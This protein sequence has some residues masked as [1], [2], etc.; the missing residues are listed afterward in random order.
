MAVVARGEKLIAAWSD[1]SGLHARLLT[2][3]G[4]VVGAAFRLGERCNGGLAMAENGQSGRLACMRVGSDSHGIE[5]IDILYDGS[6]RSVARIPTNNREGRGV[7]LAIHGSETHVVWSE[8]PRAHEQVWRARLGDGRMSVPECLSNENAFAIEPDVLFDGQDWLVAWAEMS[9]ADPSAKTGRVMLSNGH[10]AP[11]PLSNVFCISPSP[12]ISRD[13]TGLLVAFRDVR[14]PDVHAGLFLMRPDR[15][16][17]P[18]RVA[19]ANAF[20]AEDIAYCQ[21]GL[22]ASTPR[23][24]RSD[25]LVGLSRIDENLV[26]LGH[27]I[28]IYQTN[29]DLALA[30]LACIAR[31]TL[32]VVADESTPGN[33][34]PLIRAT[35]LLC[36]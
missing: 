30:D 33:S 13:R 26:R 1:D 22:F 17:P 23:T 32:A 8:G 4:S 5:L 12:R 10:G 18:K 28:Q 2:A 6:S 15:H 35:P 3:T 20:G 7:A 31:G 11:S 19:R 25:S 14:A 21:R 27:E 9:T 16:E 29:A 34:H 24:F 36:D